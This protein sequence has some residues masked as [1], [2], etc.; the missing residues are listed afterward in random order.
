MRHWTQ[1]IAERSRPDRENYRLSSPFPDRLR[2]VFMYLGRGGALGRFL[3]SLV[4]SAGQTAGLDASFVVSRTNAGTL[5]LPADTNVLALPTF[6]SRSPVAAIENFCTS[7]RTLLSHLAER[8]PHAV[9]NLMPHVWTPLWVSGI[10]RTGTSHVTVM[11]DAKGHPG[12]PTGPLVPWLRR[13][14]RSADLVVTLSRHVATQLRQLAVAPPGRTAQLFLPDFKYG[15][16]GIPRRRR[17][18]R[19][20]RLLFFGRILRYK[21]LPLLLDALEMLRAEGVAVDLGVV[22]VGDLRGQRVRLESLGA[23]IINR[24]VD[25]RAVCSLLARYEAMVLP[26]IECS[27]SASAAT[28]FGSGMP[29]VGT[30]VGGLAEQIS[31]GVNGVLAREATARSLADG[32]RT[33]ATDAALYGRICA[34]LRAGSQERSM[35]QFLSVLL[36][37]IMQ[38]QPHPARIASP[39]GIAGRA[40][41][42]S[43]EYSPAD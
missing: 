23:E 25:D 29:V 34:N 39:S 9:V 21:G 43:P 2:V 36:R 4:D 33:L 22:G 20:L 17:E 24:W 13:E 11:H 7:R 10:R 40:I 42:A 3:A 1:A 14:A 32:I 8:R 15:A 5:A 41:H 30:P 35:R 37:E 28:A 31:N 6:E 27:Q 38:L 19:P 18:E 26:Y 16:H 12:D